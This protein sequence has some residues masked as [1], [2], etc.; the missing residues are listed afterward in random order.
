MTTYIFMPEEEWKH[1]LSVINFGQSAFDARAIR[2]MNEV[3]R[4]V[5]D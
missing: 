5:R 1:F 3:K 4:E 2:A